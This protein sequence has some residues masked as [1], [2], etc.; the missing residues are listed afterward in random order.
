MFIA[1][2]EMKDC[3]SSFTLQEQ[4]TKLLQIE[5]DPDDMVN[6][7]AYIGCLIYAVTC[8]RPQVA[9]A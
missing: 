3:K 8:A 4:A 9:K 1:K 2:F 5:K 7:Q 6:C